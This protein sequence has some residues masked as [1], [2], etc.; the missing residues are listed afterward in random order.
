MAAA[1]DIHPAIKEHLLKHQLCTDDDAA[2]FLFPKLKELPSPFLLKSIEHAVD[3]IIESIRNKDD[4]LIWGDYDVD[5]IT[6]TSLLFSFF[7]EIGVSVVCH[8][9]NRLTE[10]YGL[11][12]TKLREFSQKLSND[13][14]LITV[15]CGISN[16]EE[17]LLAKK[18]G[19]KTIVTDH[20]RVPDGELY[21]DATINPKQKDC[22]FPFDNL[23]GVG[24]AFYLASAVRSKIVDNDV[25]SYISVPNLKSFLGYVAIGTIAD[26]MPLT[27]V[28]RVLVK[29]GFESISA[30]NQN[31]IKALFET[32]DIDCRLLTSESISFKIAPAINA[33]GRLGESSKPLILF[34]S[35]SIAEAKEHSLNLIQLNN[36]RKQITEINYENALTFARKELRYQTNCL[37]ILGDFHEG[38][39]GIIASKMVEEFI[40]PTL[41][42][43]YQPKDRNLIKGSGR[44]PAGYNLYDLIS[45][46]S[47]HLINFGGHELAAGF[48]L[49]AD[50][51]LPFKEQFESLNSKE[52]EKKDQNIMVLAPGFINLN[53]SEAFNK[54]LLDNLMQL[55]P[56]GEANPKPKFLDRS[57]Q[58]IS[59]SSFGRNRA[60]LKGL[61]RG[62]FNNVQV[63]GFN[64]ADRISSV[65][66]NEPC[67]LAFSH[68]LDSFNGKTSWKI[69]IKDI[70]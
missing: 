41:V 28:N 56:T 50:N 45:G 39:L 68:S 36:K 3:I 25:F 44:T 26:I 7:K 46:A 57:A 16:G 65:N 64:L 52:N 51:F 29:G 2:N 23:S 55:E 33:A 38:V 24:V 6:G 62:K 15:D 14:L 11:N 53:I 42:C 17:L 31:G 67:N 27:G 69:L 9:P 43:C 13:K 70:W 48:S 47:H 37:V 60:H 61:V 66:L 22:R 20:H 63:I 19:F 21:A 5:G 12:D 35:D 4:I 32:L 1:I 58:F 54:T 18:Y 40:I 8:I 30:T 49:S 34:M 10:G 59:Y